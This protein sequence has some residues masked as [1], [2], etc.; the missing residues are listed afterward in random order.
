MTDNR[1]TELLREGLTEHGIE[2]RG[3]LEGVTFVGDWCF[4]EYDNGKLAATCEPVLT[5]EQAIAATLGNKRATHGTLTADQVRE[6]VEKHWHDLPD[7]YDMPEATALPEYS[8]DWQA[9]ADELN[10][11]AER[12]CRNLDKHHNIM[13]KCSECGHWECQDFDVEKIL[14]QT[15]NYCPNCGRRVIE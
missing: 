13:F 3:G 7:E 12:T 14:P 11:C 15:W 4:V 5:P 10:V 8:Y 2:W 1:T 9:I 6:T